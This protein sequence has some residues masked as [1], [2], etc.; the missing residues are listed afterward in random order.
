L[1]AEEMED[2]DLEKRIAI[3]KKMLNME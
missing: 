3:G 2:E 1:V